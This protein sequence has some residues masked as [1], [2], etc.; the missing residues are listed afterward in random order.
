[1]K[2]Y[3]RKRLDALD[4]PASRAAL[5]PFVLI[6]ITKLPDADRESYWCGDDAV[7]TRHGARVGVESSPG[8]IH[9][10]VISLHPESRQEWL[11]TRDMDDDDLEAY[12]Q[13]MIREDACRKR[14]AQAEQERQKTEAMNAKVRY[15]YSGYPTIDDGVVGT[16]ST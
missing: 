8:T 4:A 11:I 10:P 14:E 6:D 3:I 5:R 13:R 16:P 15:D 2:A 12:E 9:T 1:V 7:L